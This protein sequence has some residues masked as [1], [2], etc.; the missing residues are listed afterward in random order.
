MMDRRTEYRNS[1]RKNKNNCG[2]TV[3]NYECQPVPSYSLGKMIQ[4][5]THNGLLLVIT[6]SFSKSTYNYTV[7]SN[8]NNSPPPQKN[9]QPLTFPLTL[10]CSTAASRAS[11]A[12]SLSASHS[13]SCDFCNNQDKE[14]FIND[15]LHVATC[16]CFN[17]IQFKVRT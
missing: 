10:S 2:H 12:L 11:L 17:Q 16:R 6:V 14:I 9:Q 1:K 3:F 8:I 5:A 7:H 13:S 4:L 15:G